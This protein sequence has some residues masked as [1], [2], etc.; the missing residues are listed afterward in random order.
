MLVCHHLEFLVMLTSFTWLTDDLLKDDPPSK[1]GLSISAAHNYVFCEKYESAKRWNFSRVRRQ[2]SLVWP[3]TTD[4]QTNEL[5]RPQSGSVK[6]TVCAGKRGWQ[7]LNSFHFA[8]DWFKDLEMLNHKQWFHFHD[9][10]DAFLS[11]LSFVFF[12]FFFAGV[13]SSSRPWT[14]CQRGYGYKVLRYQP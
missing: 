1:F 3:I 8:S 7:S 11:L 13:L 6:P 14:L 2:K 4:K 10:G 12:V 9:N 5:V